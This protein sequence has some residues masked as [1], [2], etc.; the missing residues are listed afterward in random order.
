[1]RVSGT[2]QVAYSYIEEMV[3]VT[4]LAEQVEP[5]GS[6]W[7]MVYWNPGSQ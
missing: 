6:R 1:M 3:S 7:G 2:L 5:I 4:V